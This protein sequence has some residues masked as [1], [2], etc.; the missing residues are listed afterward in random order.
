MKKVFFLVAGTVITL[1][2][3][4]LNSTAATVVNVEEVTATQDNKEKIEVSALPDAIKAVLASDAF[5]GFTAE[6]AF[7]IKGE[8]VIYEVSGKNGEQAAT[9]RFDEAGNVVS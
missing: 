3:S 6:S 2:F 1:G 5:Q 9:I 7:V 8:R 4:S